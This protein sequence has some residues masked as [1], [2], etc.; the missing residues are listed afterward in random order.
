MPTDIDGNHYMLSPAKDINWLRKLFE[1]AVLGFYTIRLK[2]IC[3]VKSENLQW[4]TQEETE[5]IKE[6]WPLKNIHGVESPCA[7]NI[8]SDAT[9]FYDSRLI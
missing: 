5:K 8:A 7:T 2:D 6:I 1:K 4:D 9:F 3:E